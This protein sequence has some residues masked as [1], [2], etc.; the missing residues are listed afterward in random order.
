M[1]ITAGGLASST[2]QIAYYFKPLE[3]SEL[4]NTAPSLVLLLD[5]NL[6][7]ACS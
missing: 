6:L 5:G 3:V 4:L 2:P 7:D 1:Q